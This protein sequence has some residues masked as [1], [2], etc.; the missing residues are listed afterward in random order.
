MRVAA[1]S[2]A[3]RPANE[4]A[5]RARCLAEAFRAFLM[6]SNSCLS[7]RE[8]LAQPFMTGLLLE[9]TRAPWERQS[10]LW[11]ETDEK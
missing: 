2:K 9:E 6:P 7:L 3:P 1:L 11:Q 5:G 4:G 8:T 10:L